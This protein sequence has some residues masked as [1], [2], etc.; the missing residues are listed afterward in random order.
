MPTNP[1]HEKL[2]E[3]FSKLN[4]CI[5]RPE[6]VQ[7]G[8]QDPN[9]EYHDKKKWLRTAFL[10]IEQATREECVDVIKNTKQPEDPHSWQ[11]QIGFEMCRR[12]VKEAIT[13]L[14]T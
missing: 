7:Q 2:I 10:Q 6:W 5:C 14:T 3:Q 11:Y 8:M 1:L 13:K 12:L 9:C 4:P